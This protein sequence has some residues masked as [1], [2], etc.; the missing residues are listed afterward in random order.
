MSMPD[1][2]RRNF[3]IGAACLCTAAATGCA[4][5]QQFLRADIQDSRALIPVERLSKEHATIVYIDALAA[6]LAI[7][8]IRPDNGT[9]LDI[10]HHT[11]IDDAIWRALLL[12]CT[13]RG[14]NVA[15]D[16]RGY[17]CPCHGSRFDDDGDVTV[18]P[19]A[20]PLTELPCIQDGEHVIVTLPI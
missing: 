9:S 5:Q 8:H 16:R 11:D 1:L 3:L 17:E 14:C 7:D 13:H 19:A 12:V 18:G 2:S 10:E 4:A 6:S 20:D 15:P